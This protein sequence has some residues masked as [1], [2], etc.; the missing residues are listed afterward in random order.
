MKKGFATSAILYTL[1]LLFLVLMVGILD[2]L[3]NKKTILDSLKTDTI[4][5][6]QQDTITDAILEQIGLINSKI[7]EIETKF[8][9][10]YTKTEVDSLLHN[11]SM[12]EIQIKSQSDL[13]NALNPWDRYPNKT[14]T[15]EL[16]MVAVPDLSLEGGAWIVETCRTNAYGWQ[17]ATKYNAHS[18]DFNQPL[19]RMERN[20]IEGWGPWVTSGS[21][22]ALPNTTITTE[23]ELSAAIDNIGKYS[24]GYCT[25]ETINV[26][27]SIN[28]PGGIWVFETCK[29][30]PNTAYQI[31]KLYNT[32]GIVTYERSYINGKWNS[33]VDVHS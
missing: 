13:D 5:A 16:L 3:Q 24:T 28:F 33:W 23:A 11:T 26:A 29:T 18:N 4:S 20:Y 8:K 2:N 10:Y 9:D 7:A 30:T 21:L 32:T 14:C 25:K 17:S 22:V 15:R 12:Y 1:L 27:V 31:G 6:L 19:L